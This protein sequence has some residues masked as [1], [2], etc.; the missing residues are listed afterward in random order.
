MSKFKILFFA[1]FFVVFCFKTKAQIIDKVI[2]VVGKYPIMLSDL[3]NALA[4]REKQQMP[5][6]SCLAFEALVFQKLL[7][8]QADRDSVVVSDDEVDREL[9]QRMSYY[10]QQFGSEQKLEEFYGKRINVIKDELRA[11]VSEQLVADRMKNKITGDRKLTPSEVRQYYNTLPQ[12]SLPLVDSEVELQQITKKPSYSAEAKLQAKQRLEE[13]Q[14][15]V[16]K[17]GKRMKTLAVLYSDDPGSAKQGG[18]IE[19]VPRGVMDPAFESV[20]FRLKKGEVSNV[21]E[22]SYGYHFIQLIQRKGDLVDL[23]HILLIPKMNISD[24]V[25]SKQQLDS[26]Y[27][28]ITNGTITFEE[29]AKKYSDD[30]DTKQNGGLMINQQTAN[31]RFSNEDIS[32]MD[33]N[34]IVTMNSLKIGDISKPMEF[35]GPDGKRGYRLLRLKNRID[36]HK[37]NLKDDYQKLSMMANVDKS[38][39]LIKDWIRKRSKITYIKLDPAFSCQFENQ[40][41]INN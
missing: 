20:A 13:Y 17:D 6:N 16:V 39:K 12:D 7:V 35:Y 18:I 34:L 40:W 15:E 27:N 8:A 33:P 37:T 32:Q 14:L 21:F 3:Q 26:I 2:G 41:T 36:P 31:T 11:D 30:K 5:L 38:K 22:S 10:I 24:F 29:A 19:N 4:E 9:S 23:R 25:R 1:V 28:E